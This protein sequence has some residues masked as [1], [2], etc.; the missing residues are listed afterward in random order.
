[1]QPPQ[2]SHPQVKLVVC[3]SFFA[4]QA[5][6]DVKGIFALLR[7][8]FPSVN[9]VVVPTDLRIPTEL[10]QGQDQQRRLLQEIVDADAVV[11]IPS[12]EA[13]GRA[14][15]LRWVHHPVSGFE[16]ARDHPLVESPVVLTNAPGAHVPAMADWVLAMML[17]WCQ[18]VEEHFANQRSKQWRPHDFCRYEEDYWGIEEMSGAHTCVIGMGGLGE[19]TVIC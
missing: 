12:A 1:M 7:Q 14:T 16:L 11:G 19:R 3:D 2:P 4:P 18:R 10:E 8:D 5:A 9:V 17:S 15:K 6:D 13:F